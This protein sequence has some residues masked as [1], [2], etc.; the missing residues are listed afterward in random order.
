MPTQ[1]P[2]PANTITLRMRSVTLRSVAI[3]IARPCME[4]ITSASTKTGIQAAQPIPLAKA[5]SSRMP[6]SS[7]ARIRAATIVPS[8]QPWQ[9]KSGSAL[10]LRYFSANGCMDAS[11]YRLQ[12]LARGVESPSQLGQADYF[13]L[14]VG[15]PVDLA[16]DLADVHLGHHDPPRL[17]GDPGDLRSGEGPDDPHLEETGLDA[18]CASLAHRPHRGPHGAAVGDD[19]DVGVLQVPPLHVEQVAVVQEHLVAQ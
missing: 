3:G 15:G 10:F 13:A 18:P 9:K 4:W 6:R 17:G 8:P 7:I 11:L 14:S 12:D 2:C 1:S 19:H 5:T 16:H